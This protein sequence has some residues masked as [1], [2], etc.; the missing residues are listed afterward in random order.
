MENAKLISE[1]MALVKIDQKSNCWKWKGFIEKNGYGKLS[2]KGKRQWAHIYFYNIF[3]GDVPDGLE[4]DHVCRNHGCVNPAH[5]E[6]VTH[7]ENMRR[8]PVAVWVVRRAKT[9][10]PHGHPYSGDNLI[11][12]GGFR[13][14]RTC[15]NKY[16]NA[17]K[18]KIICEKQSHNRKT[19]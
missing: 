18:K 14:C 1:M 11:T 8:S 12:W 2:V 10:C 15:Q 19:N 6:P 13:Y 9:H 3:V 4:L 5:L 7:K 16:K 17:Y